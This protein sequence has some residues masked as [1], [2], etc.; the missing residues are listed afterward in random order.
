MRISLRRDIGITS[1]VIVSTLVSACS[2]LPP[3]AQLPDIPVMA[4]VSEIAP[5]G[6]TGMQQV[7]GSIRNE[8]PNPVSTVVVQFGGYDAQGYRTQT[9]N[10]TGGPLPPQGE[11]RFSAS[12]RPP[13]DQVKVER[14]DAL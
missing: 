9:L 10:V 5:A 12:C 11:E 7:L 6:G 4:T 8:G 13:C 1:V 3:V 2:A 14:I